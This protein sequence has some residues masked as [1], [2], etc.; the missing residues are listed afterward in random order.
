MNCFSFCNKEITMRN[1]LFL[2][3]HHKYIISY[4]YIYSIYISDIFICLYYI[5]II[6]VS[7]RC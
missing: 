4:I 3:L 5:Y 7:S 2:F 1:F 6:C